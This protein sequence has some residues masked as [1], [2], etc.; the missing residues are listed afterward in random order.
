MDS[1]E[2]SFVPQWIRRGAST[3]AQSKQ[4]ITHVKMPSASLPS[5]Q[6]AGLQLP[7]QVLEY[8]CT[9]IAEGPNHIML[10]AMF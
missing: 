5:G 1:A 8:A 4:G 3:G 9:I 6:L 10:A 7:I 2:P